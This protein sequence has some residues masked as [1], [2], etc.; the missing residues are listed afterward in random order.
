MMETAMVNE[1][2]NRTALQYRGNGS[3]SNGFRSIQLATTAQKLHEF[4]TTCGLR[5][6]F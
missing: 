5:Q 1:R 3:G 4:A 6:Q 2:S